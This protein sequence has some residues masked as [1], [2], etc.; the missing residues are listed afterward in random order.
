MAAVIGSSVGIGYAG[1]GGDGT[2]GGGAFFRCY[3]GQNGA[4]PLFQLS[5]D[6]EFLASSQVVSVDQAQQLCTPATGH[7]DVK[8]GQQYAF[9]DRTL[10]D[11]FTCYDIP[12]SQSPNDAVTLSDPLVGSQS[13]LLGSPPSVCIQSCKSSDGT[14]CD[15]APL[16]VGKAGGVNFYQCY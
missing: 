14:N 10:V 9:V 3:E 12:T 11:Q 15:P 13:V 5:I 4:A 16:E 7:I 1:S 8:K 2:A 6:D